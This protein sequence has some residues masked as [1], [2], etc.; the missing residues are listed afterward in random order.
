MKNKTTAALLSLILGVFGVQFF[1]L[2]RIGLGIFMCMLTFFA[3]KPQIAAFV[4]LINFIL[5]LTKSDDEFNRRYNKQSWKQQQ[6]QSGKHEN[7]NERQEAAHGQ[8]QS[9][10]P[11]SGIFMSPKVFLSVEARMSVAMT[12]A[13]KTMK[14]MT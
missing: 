12:I 11:V 1:Y 13:A 14:T 7:W 8:G 9:F 3:G 2:G 4:G 5:F 10:C 6:R